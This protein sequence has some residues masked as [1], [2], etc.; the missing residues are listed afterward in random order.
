MEKSL[1][2]PENKPKRSAALR[3]KVNAVARMVKMFRIL[4]E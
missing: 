3:K 4:R 2:N 1:E